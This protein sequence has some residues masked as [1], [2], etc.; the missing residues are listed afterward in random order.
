MAERFILGS[1]GLKSSLGYKFTS[2]LHPGTVYTFALGANQSLPSFSSTPE[3]GLSTLP[4]RG[5]MAEMNHGE[6]L[7]GQYCGR[8]HGGVGSGGGALPDLGRSPDSIHENFAA[9]VRQGLLTGTGMPNFGRRLSQQD[10]A[11]LQSY[12]LSQAEKARKK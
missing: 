2:S 6:L 12:I 11:D 1:I 10:V 3:R 8:C 7:Y 5:S 9:I 4:G